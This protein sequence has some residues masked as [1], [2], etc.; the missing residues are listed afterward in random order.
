MYL[1]KDGIKVQAEHPADIK[2]FKSL[3][4]V[5]AQAGSPDPVETKPAEKGKADRLA[6]KGGE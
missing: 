2:R 6:K 5:E 4:F 3:G 1:T